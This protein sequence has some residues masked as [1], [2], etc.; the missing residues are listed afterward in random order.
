MFVV[1][2]PAIALAQTTAPVSLIDSAAQPSI[3]DAT[4]PE[5]GSAMVTFVNHGSVP[6]TQVDF[7]LSSNGEALTTL[8]DT[9]TFSPGVAISHTFA[10]DRTERDLQLSIADVKFADGTEWVNDAPLPQGQRA[11]HD[12]MANPDAD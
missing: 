11:V 6:A 2:M 3:E 10:T 4:R 1:G 9:G 5:N 7:T 12:W 8:T